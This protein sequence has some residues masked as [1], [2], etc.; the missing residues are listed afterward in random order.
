[1]TAETMPPATKTG[2]FGRAWTCDV[3]AFA[4][5][6]GIAPDAHATL[7]QWIIE[8]RW[9]HP[10][11]DSY[12]IILMHLRP[13]ADGRETLIHREGATHEM[14]VFALNPEH[15]RSPTIH[16]TGPVHFLQPVN[17]G[18]QL[19]EPDDAAAMTRIEDTVDRIINGTLNPDTD[20]LSQ[21]IA[22]FGDHMLKREWQ[23]SR[24]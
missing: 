24:G 9:A 12:A 19:V 3:D 2:P 15:P 11:W 7:A 18:A 14:L 10:I 1:M 6:K 17:F 21:W 23:T 8:A 20:A 16:G 4:L 13:M 22:L 5:A